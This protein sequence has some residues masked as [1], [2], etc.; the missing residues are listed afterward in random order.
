[1]ISLM[2]MEYCTILEQEFLHMKVNLRMICAT[3][4]ESVTLRMARSYTKGNGKMTIMPEPFY[5]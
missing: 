1:M 3:V 4:T 2:A 5:F